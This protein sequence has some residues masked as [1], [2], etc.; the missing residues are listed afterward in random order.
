MFNLVCDKPVAI[1]SPDHIYPHGTAN[2]NSKNYNFNKFI[3]GII[4]ANP[5]S[6]IDIGC[7]GGGMIEDFLNDGCVAVGLE[8][9]N[10][11]LLNKRACWATIPEHLFTCDVTENYQLY[12]NDREFTAHVITA[13]EVME[14]FKPEKVDFVLSQI[15]KHL[16]T[17]GLFICSISLGNHGNE[18][19]HQCVQTIDWWN[20]KFHNR[21]FKIR[22]D[23]KKH[24]H[25]ND[26]WVRYYSN[27]YN[28][29]YQKI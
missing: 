7:S 18:T 24:I 15:H 21:G 6:I 22:E 8:G 14:H 9:S 16:K 20:E 13:W 5:I 23:L 12:Y 3:Y 10:Y 25:S 28:Q 26:A 19:W 2:D 29:V 1:D 27:D 4:D 17:N 11:S